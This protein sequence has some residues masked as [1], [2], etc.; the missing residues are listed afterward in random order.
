MT[1]FE[2][3]NWLAQ[4]TEA[5]GG[6]AVTSN[7]PFLV[8]TVTCACAELQALGSDLADPVK[9]DAI[10]TYLTGKPRGDGGGRS[11]VH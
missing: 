9:R 5:G 2:P 7:G 3:A 8:H 1:Q 10:H 11:K 4:W 6:W